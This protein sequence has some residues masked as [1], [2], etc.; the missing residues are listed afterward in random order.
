MLQRVLS[1]RNVFLLMIIVSCG[2]IACEL[3]WPSGVN[4][5]PIPTEYLLVFCIASMALAAF[6]AHKICLRLAA[7]TETL[8]D[9]EFAKLLAQI[10]PLIMLNLH[11]IWKL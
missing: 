9:K 4:P 11:K 2:L 8:T 3:A 5:T 7:G 10:D 6:I 1:V